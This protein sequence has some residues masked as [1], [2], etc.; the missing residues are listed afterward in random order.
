MSDQ[1]SE[2]IQMPALGRPFQLGMLY[3]IR[4]DSIVPGI[5]LPCCNVMQKNTE[6]TP[7]PSTKFCFLKHNSIEE[8]M[9]ALDIDTPLKASWL[10]GML[11]VHGSAKFLNDR[12]TSQSQVRATLQYK[13]TTR[14]EQ[15]K[16]NMQH[17]DDS[18]LPVHSA[19]HLVTAIMYG[20]QTFFVFDKYTRSMEQ[21]E[22]FLKDLQKA[23]EN[24]MST[25][26]E[27]GC[28]PSNESVNTDSLHGFNCTVYSDI[29]L[30]EEIICQEAAT[31]FPLLPKLLFSKENYEVPMVVWLYPLRNLGHLEVQRTTQISIKSVHCIQALFEDLNRIEMRCNDMMENNI[32]VMFPEIKHRLCVFNE[33]LREYKL[34]FQNVLKTAVLSAP[35]YGSSEQT[36][37][38]YLESNR[39]SLFSNSLLNAWLDY[40]ER[41]TAVL[42]FFVSMLHAKKIVTSEKDLQKEVWQMLTC[43][44]H[45]ICFV[46]TSV[47]EENAYLSDLS[48]CLRHGS[49]SLSF[50]RTQPKNDQ[51]FLSQQLV[52]EMKAKCCAFM[53]FERDNISMYKAT[54]IAASVNNK[55]HKGATIYW[56]EGGFLKTEDFQP[57]TKPETPSVHKV[58][59]NS[60]TLKMQPPLCGNK[61]VDIHY[62]Y[63]FNSKQNRCVNGNIEEQLCTVSGL[64]SGI[65][66]TFWYRTTHPGFSPMSDTTCIR[67]LVANR[68][69]FQLLRCVPIL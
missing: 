19:T 38:I 18:H 58:T 7:H 16:M 24:L 63:Y 66:Y 26:K 54:F 31:I 59:H 37:D 53:N 68:M 46:L 6:I 51:W 55:R 48:R 8:K 44:E 41:E 40:Q 13:T 69:N 28:Q 65:A 4:T 34:L 39:Q 11:K 12:N 42:A 10:S 15:L 47:S 52:E 3:D 20:A 30:K 56:Y 36:F 21:K 64:D 27:S 32:V 5:N 43:T 1:S 67:T 45:V 14:F 2:I 17:S 29:L 49:D 57:P 25:G 62:M 61:N 22:C 50:L 35:Q 23:F 60:V 9:S 33:G